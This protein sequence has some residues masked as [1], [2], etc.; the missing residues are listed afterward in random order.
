MTTEPK[1]SHSEAAESLFSLHLF[2][3]V[4]DNEDHAEAIRKFSL[5]NN[6][7]QKVSGSL[8]V[9]LDIPF[10]LCMAGR[11]KTY[12]AR[13]EETDKTLRNIL[14]KGDMITEVDVNEAWHATTSDMTNPL[15]N[16]EPPRGQERDHADR[17]TIKFL[18]Y[19]SEITEEEN[20]RLKKLITK[21][22]QIQFEMGSEVLT[23]I[24]VRDHID[25]HDTHFLSLKNVPESITSQYRQKFSPLEKEIPFLNGDG[26]IFKIESHAKEYNA[27]EIQKVL[28]EVTQDLTSKIAA[29]RQF[30]GRVNDKTPT[31]TIRFYNMTA[32]GLLNYPFPPL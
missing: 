13:N 2:W 24:V 10:V 19:V 25:R 17:Q 9:K 4:K 16:E 5:E 18:S 26:L 6:L 8:A 30:Y 27:P 11:G 3:S 14:N 28:S 7:F 20:N 21:S 22:W 31:S 12:C 29:C 15:L 23:S 1:L 32:T